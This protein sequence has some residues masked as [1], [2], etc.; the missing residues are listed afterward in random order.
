MRTTA[1]VVVVG[2]GI[3]GCAAA[4]FLT[5]RGLSVTL[6]EK[7]QIAGEQ[8]SRNWGWVRQ[9]GRN[10][11]ELPA[12]AAS[13]GI[14]RGLAD[15]LG[16]DVGWVSAGNIDLAYD[17]SELVTMRA[18]QEHATAAG[19]ATRILTREEVLVRVPVLS[20][21][22]IGGIESMG[23]GQADPHLAAPALA[24][25]AERAGAE[26]LSGVAVESIR[27][28]GEASGTVSDGTRVTGVVTER[29]VISTPVVVVAGG[30]WS[31]RLLW[32]LGLRLPQRKV[33]STVLATT[34]VTPVTDVVLW[35][36]GVAI[37]Q[38]RDGRFIL[39]GGARSHYDVDLETVRFLPRFWRAMMDARRRGGPRY[40]VGRS[41]M[42]DARSMLPGPLGTEVWDATKGEEPEPDV[43]GAWRTFERFREVMPSVGAVGSGVGV[44]RIWAGYI[45]YTPDAIPVIDRPDRRG[46]GPS[47]LVISTGFSG[48]GFMLGPVGGLLASQLAV[49]E[50]TEVDVRSFRL[51]RFVEGDT[52]EGE[53]HF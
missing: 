16:E 35:A 13:V 9:N 15:A 23:D 1:D 3:V 14:W 46:E 39:A 44:E 19:I 31:S 25:A 24:R 4:W 40:H 48:H 50:E 26:V 27:V 29:G 21:S 32:P 52:A 51:S 36:E 47:G 11:R 49:G 45:D 7:G 41:L 30:A 6:V 2:G 10:V 42:R 22:F 18:W 37:R 53:L 8:S 34:P 20:D 28:E 38:G 12:A 5:Q 33:R 17:E 43:A